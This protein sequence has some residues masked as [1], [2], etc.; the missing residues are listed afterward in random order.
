MCA[1]PLV[2]SPARED[3]GGASLHRQEPESIVQA[4]ETPDRNLGMRSQ[5]TSWVALPGSQSKE[6]TQGVQPAASTFRFLSSSNKA[7]GSLPAPC[8]PG[9][10]GLAL[11][12]QAL[13][14]LRVSRGLPSPVTLF[15]R[16][17]SGKV[18]WD[19]HLTEPEVDVARWSRPGQ[20]PVLELQVHG[21]FHQDGIFPQGQSICL[22]PV[23]H[24]HSKHTQY[25]VTASTAALT[26][27]Q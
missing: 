9:H 13:V 17:P 20:S 26:P 11:A 12:L 21:A 25:A 18:L 19:P 14:A 24:T 15:T 10:G 23:P 7:L 4:G 3:K 16:H 2:A 27:G 5:E 22:P 1:S 6:A 8:P